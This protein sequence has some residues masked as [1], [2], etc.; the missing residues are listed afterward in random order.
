ME[1]QIS[2]VADGLEKLPWKAEEKDKDRGAGAIVDIMVALEK[3]APRQ[4]L[5][6]DCAGQK[7]PP[8]WLSQWKP[9]DL[10]NTWLNPG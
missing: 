1:N 7:A 5:E 2:D 4:K 8:S 10:T 6:T 3:R 9:V